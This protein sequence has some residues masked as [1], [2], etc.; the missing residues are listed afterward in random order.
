MTA[1]SSNKQGLYD[2]LAKNTELNSDYS[3]RTKSELGSFLLLKI[4]RSTD[5][6]LRV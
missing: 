1:E 3:K 6:W 5:S 4:H 2:K